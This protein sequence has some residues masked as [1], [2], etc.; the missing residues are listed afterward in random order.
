MSSTTA[1]T[2]APQGTHHYVL[3]LDL[4]GRMATTWTGTLTPGTTDTRHD[5]YALLRRHITAEI[6]EYARANVVFF[7]LEPNQL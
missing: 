6:P 3:T 2:A 4:P 7:A 5:I 1:P